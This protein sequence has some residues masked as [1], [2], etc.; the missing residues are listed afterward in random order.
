M[1]AIVKAPAVAI[2]LL[3]T[4]SSTQ[5]VAPCFRYEHGDRTSKIPECNRRAASKS[6]T[7][8]TDGHNA[9]S[10]GPNAG[11]MDQADAHDARERGL[12]TALWGQMLEQGV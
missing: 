2:C 8:P 6:W 10:F 7:D 5:V 3:R 11:W 1:L 12:M 9:G 4:T